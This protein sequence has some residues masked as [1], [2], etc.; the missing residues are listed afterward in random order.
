M[1][2]I[3]ALVRFFPYWAIPVILVLVETALFAKRRRR[4]G[5]MIACLT[6]AVLFV[7]TVGVWFYYRGDVHSDHWVREVFGDV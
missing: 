6:F 5:L 2:S 4:T 3:F 7:L 1:H